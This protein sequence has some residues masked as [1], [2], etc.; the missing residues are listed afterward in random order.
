[1]LLPP[2]RGGQDESSIAGRTSGTERPGGDCILHIGVF[3]SHEG[4]LPGGVQL[5]CLLSVLFQQA[6]RAPVLRI[7]YGGPG[8]PGPRRKCG[9]GRREVLVDWRSRRS[10]GQREEREVGGG[11]LRS[12]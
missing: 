8:A 10:M 7:Q 5:P 3:P 2:T 11:E 6:S 4:G 12:F 1:M 9:F